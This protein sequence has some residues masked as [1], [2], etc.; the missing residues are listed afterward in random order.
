MCDVC[1]Q[2]ACCVCACVCAL[3]VQ[4]CVCVCVCECLCTW[5][6]VVAACITVCMHVHHYFC[7]EHMQF[8]RY[9]RM[10]AG[11]CSTYL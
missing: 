4:V 2:Y 10:Y 7:A 8:M 5:V 9:V 3:Y 6:H 1:I 11:V